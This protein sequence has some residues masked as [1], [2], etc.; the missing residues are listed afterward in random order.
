MFREAAQAPEAVGRQLA[1]NA[2]R[3]R[4]LGKRLRAFAPRAVVTCARGS[5]DH[6]ATY[7]KYLLETRLGLLTA[8]AAP[9][10]ASVY[11][12]RQDLSDCL[13]VAI[14]QSGRSPDLL[15][16][17]RAAREAG[18]LVVALVNAEGSPL[19]ALADETL[20]LA[21][22]EEASVAATKSY[23]GAL[24]AIAHLIA[25]W[26]EDAALGGALEGAPALLSRA[27]ELDWSAA[28]PMLVRASSL[29]VIARG[30]GL[31][32]AQEAALKLK[33]TCGLHAEAYSGAEVRHGPQALLGSAFPA[34]LFA[35]DD[36]AR[37]GLEALAGELV[38]RGVEVASAGAAAN[39]VIA[40]PTVEADPAL[41][42]LAFAQS[43]Y[44]LANAVSLARGH[45]P[46]SPPHLAKVTE[47]H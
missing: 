37:A 15:V 13:F 33:E 10:V 28:Q 41:A 21:A 6:A 3:V 2:G 45:D 34:M 5:S 22:G 35:Q 23:I 16:T 31:G 4:E 14:S 20:P 32:V 40:L 39:G 9:S 46:D 29:F 11:G 18:A 8:S 7:A 43:F 12:S 36:A 17:T 25:E 47:T 42:P 27:W 30:V 26:S 44:R 38:A 24:A 19:A 1:A